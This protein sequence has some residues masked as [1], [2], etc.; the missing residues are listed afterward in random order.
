MINLTVITN[1]AKPLKW[2]YNPPKNHQLMDTRSLK[3]WE[4][5][6]PYLLGPAGYRELVAHHLDLIKLMAP[7]VTNLIPSLQQFSESH[8][9]RRFLRSLEILDRCACAYTQLEREAAAGRP[10]PYINFANLN[11]EPDTDEIL[12]GFSASKLKKLKPTFNPCDPRK[13]TLFNLGQRRN[14]NTKKYSKDPSQWECHLCHQKGHIR[15]NCPLNKRK[16]M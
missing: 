2:P 14:T 5:S 6:R 3:F 4:T 11:P 15:R 8:L 9:H 13:S 10:L 7:Q 1:S 12:P 16:P